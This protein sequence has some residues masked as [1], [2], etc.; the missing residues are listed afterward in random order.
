MRRHRIIEALCQH[1]ADRARTV[2]PIA[3]DVKA[4]AAACD[5]CSYNLDRLRADGPINLRAL[6]NLTAE[7]YVRCA[8]T[9]EAAHAVVGVAAGLPLK[10]ARLNIVGDEVHTT[11]GAAVTWGPYS[12]PVDG[13][14]AMCW[15]GQQASRRWLSDQWTD[16]TEADLV[17]VAFLGWDDTRQALGVIE[18]HQLALDTGWDLGEQM[19]TE[20][21]TQIEALADLLV[22]QRC[23]LGDEVIMGVTPR[24]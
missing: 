23:L 12:G 22:R 20:R 6:P 2:W 18:Q 7:G 4:L 17:D 1:H 9:H 3:G 16:V 15:A 8:A 19:V 13:Y 24:A 10:S 21:W 11:P 5:G 14:L